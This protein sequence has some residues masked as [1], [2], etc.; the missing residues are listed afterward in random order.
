MAFRGR[1]GSHRISVSAG[2]VL[3][4]LL[5]PGSGLRSGVANDRQ[6]AGPTPVAHPRKLFLPS[7]TIQSPLTIEL[8]QVVPYL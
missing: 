7:G 2:T 5:D 4:F 8:D 1:R 6:D 3:P